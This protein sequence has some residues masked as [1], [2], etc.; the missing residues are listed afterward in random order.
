MANPLE[1]YGIYDPEPAAP[2][3]VDNSWDIT[4][5]AKV[6]LGQTPALLKGVVGLVGATGEEALGEGGIFTGLKNYGL[7]GYTEGMQKL[8]PLQKENDDVTKAWEK[9]K[10]GDLGALV[11]WASYGVGYSLGQL[12]QSLATATVGGLVGSVMAPGAGTVVGA[13]EG[14][15]APGVIRQLAKGAIEKQVA[16]EAARLAATAEGKHLLEK[17]GEDFAAKE[18]TKMATASVAGS[19]GKTVGATL[20]MGALNAGQELGGIYGEAEGE[21]AK[22]GTRL[23]ATDLARIWGSG[24]AAAA[25]DTFGDKL[26]LDA[27][28]GKLKIGGGLGAAG[29]FGVGGVAV[30]TGEALTEGVQTA[31]ERFGAG[32]SLTDQDAINDYIN[33]MAMGGLGGG[34]VGGAGG[35]L[36]NRAVIEAQQAAARQAAFEKIS[37][38]KSVDEA[39]AAQAAAIDSANTKLT[40][41]VDNWFSTPST[42]GGVSTTTTPTTETTQDRVARMQAA[43]DKH[44]AELEEVNKQAN[45]DVRAQ[46]MADVQA[47][48]TAELGANSLTR[49]PVDVNAMPTATP[50]ADL[51]AKEA[52]V[53][54]RKDAVA[55][56]N[57]AQVLTEMP[58]LVQRPIVDS[59]PMDQRQVTNRLLVM[60]DQLRLQG[61]DPASLVAV[62]HPTKPGMYAIATQDPQV[63]LDPTKQGN[64]ALAGDA[65]V[66]VAPTPAIVDPVK[67][68]VAE[69]RKG[70]TQQDRA[71]VQA[72]DAGQITDADVQKII[73][74]DQKAANGPTPL[75][76]QP[77]G[78]PGVVAADNKKQ[79]GTSDDRTEVVAKTLPGSRD[80]AILAYVKRMRATDTPEAKQFISDYE[81]G[82]VTK[83]QWDA[84]LKEITPEVT[85][86]EPTTALPIPTENEMP[87]DAAE[88]NKRLPI[89]P[90]DPGIRQASVDKDF[91][92]L[93]EHLKNSPNPVVAR[94]GQLAQKLVGITKLTAPR[95]IIGGKPGVLGQYSYGPFA[96]NITLKTSHAG[97]EWTATHEVAH[98]VLARIMDHPTAAQKP[99]VDK[100]KELYKHVRTT[101]RAQGR[102]NLYG[103]KDIHEFMSE[104]WSNQEFQR[105]LMNIP[106]KSRSVWSQFVQA[107]ANLLG[108]KN[109]NALTEALILGEKLGEMGR[110]KGQRVHAAKTF[111][112][113]TK[114][115]STR[116]Q[117]T[118]ESPA[119]GEPKETETKDATRETLLANKVDP[120]TLPRIAGPGK[121]S[122]GQYNLIAQ[123]ARIFGK[124]V[125]LFDGKAAGVTHTGAVFTDDAKTIYLNIDSKNAHIAVFGHELMH[126]LRA[127]NPKAY[128]A[129][130]AVMKLTPDGLKEF[131]HYYDKNKSEG[132]GIYHEELISDLLGNRFMEPAFWSGVFKEIAKTNGDTIG[133]D[134]IAKLGAA[135]MRA[136]NLVVKSLKGQSNFDS[137]KF[138]ANLNEV[139]AAMQKELAAYAVAK[140]GPTEAKA[141]A[142][143]ASTA[144]TTGPGEDPTGKTGKAEDITPGYKT[145]TERTADVLEK[146]DSIAEKYPEVS[147]YRDAWI[148]GVADFGDPAAAYYVQNAKGYKQYREEILA[149]LNPLLNEDGTLTVYRYMTADQAEEISS[150]AGGDAMAVSLDPATA[151]AFGNFAGFKKNKGRSPRSV[152][153]YKTVP[154]SVIMSGKPSEKELVVSSADYGGGM[155]PVSP[156]NKK[157]STDRDSYTNLKG[158]KISYD[159]KIEDTGETAKVTIDAAKALS[160]ADKRRDALER[161][162]NCLK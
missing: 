26:G 49:A 1:Q 18:L 133:A 127:D 150:G 155:R 100:I 128:D 30:G 36:H 93:V 24:L 144:E 37:Q 71:F 44:I 114:A 23:G 129:I 2:P 154:E 17:V 119:R 8:E 94:M 111:A 162:M 91:G 64:A 82:R 130:L 132:A 149:T 77:D 48:I 53:Q 104:A 74:R 50:M 140:R 105:L 112:T 110:A 88:F 115:S 9:A 75:T 22:N 152:Y 25:A 4:R 43:I 33:S 96:D 35:A 27:L 62:P 141:P 40:T 52:G 39:I 143:V 97:D 13:A 161:L 102:S 47:Q 15:V 3:P 157:A 46:K 57:P 117:D 159:V 158:K 31:L 34:V 160:A 60:R 45:P 139:K 137:D 103:L 56:A 136:I 87:T 63:R 66:A 145:S 10:A 76:Y 153:E 84:I 65:G 55:A 122:K 148:G 32:Q 51:Q 109:N 19:Y 28:T 86:E 78:T 5:G 146:M 107:V 156:T 20:G 98:A 108:I 7:N 67:A 138:V 125:V 6:A 99:T 21:A 41:A 81:N 58:P 101:L 69:K 80:D 14:A 147:E 59:T 72:Y 85:P 68:Y 124:K 89:R 12:G 113:E 151:K 142:P 135:L 92:A 79:R 134:I 61:G 54:A 123:I 16:K 106:Y 90:N 95:N 70:G 116:E 121:I 11:D 38:A 29:R 42:D 131:G 126:Q 120:S 83:E 118:T 73:D